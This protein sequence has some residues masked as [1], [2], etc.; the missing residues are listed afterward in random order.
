MTEITVRISLSPEFE[1]EFG[2]L[3]EDEL[4][5]VVDEMLDWHAD[6][7]SVERVT[8]DTGQHAALA[9]WK[10]DECPMDGCPDHGHEYLVY[11]PEVGIV[12]CNNWDHRY[13]SEL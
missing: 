12:Y 3:S 5:G 13:R 2:R 7:M 10:V 1:Q 6:Y 11:N 8:A 4:F 9:V